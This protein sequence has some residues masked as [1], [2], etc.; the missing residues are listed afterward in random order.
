MNDQ[1]PAAPPAEKRRGRLG[2]LVIGVVVAICSIGW[3]YVV[4]NA[5]QTP[6]IAYQTI[7]FQVQSDS[8]VE[9]RWSVAKPAGDQVRC[10]VDA[11]DRNFVPVAEIEVT[12]P[13]GRSRMERTDVLPTVRRATAARVKECRTE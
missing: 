1:V 12:V 9:I 8:A 13:A 7:T 3:A 10:V 5:G 4:A 6:G 2:Y 11:V